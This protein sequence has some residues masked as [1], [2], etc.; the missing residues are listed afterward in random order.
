MVHQNKGAAL[1]ARRGGKCK[2]FQTF[3]RPTPSIANKLAASINE[4][5][6]FAVHRYRH[7]TSICEAKYFCYTLSAVELDL[8]LHATVLSARARESSDAA[9]SDHQRAREQ[10]GEEP[11]QLCFHHIDPSRSV[12]GNSA[13]R[14][15]P[16][17][18]LLNILCRAFPRRTVLSFSN[19]N[20][21]FP[22]YAK[23]T[24]RHFTFQGLN[25][26]HS[27]AFYSCETDVRS[28]RNGVLDQLYNNILEKCSSIVC[29]GP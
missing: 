24:F 7:I 6:R 26:V 12:I 5:I 15:S 29:F 2:I 22:G 13:A 1:S 16:E 3:K 18:P 25:F 27:A 23:V 11:A 28:R 9:K 14:L 17:P 10:D 4:R 20:L 8:V 19:F 21:T